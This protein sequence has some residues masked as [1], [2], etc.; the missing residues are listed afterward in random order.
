VAELTHKERL[1]PSLLDRLT[2]DDPH[3]RVEPRERRMLSV[4][5][6][7]ESVRRDLTWLFNTTH[8]AAAE[9]GLEAT[10][11]LVA[12]SVVNFGIPDLAGRTAS[13]VDLPAL[14]RLLR[15]AIW[16]FEPRLVRSSV[17]VRG[18][19]DERNM[20]HNALAFTIEA[21]LWAQP[22]PVRLSLQ[23]QIDLEDGRIQISDTAAPKGT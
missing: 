4:T 20:S 19:V 18:I 6:L 17:V 15:Q 23:T 11:P 10:T 3:S 14:E 5:Q 8:L 22:F 12:C 21:D 13:G 16:D 9:G 7:R 2:D 1:Q